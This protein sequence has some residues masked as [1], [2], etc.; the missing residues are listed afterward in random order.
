MPK[1]SVKP[2]SRIKTSVILGGCFLFG[3]IG[4]MDR[5]LYLKLSKWV[6]EK[7][8]EEGVEPYRV[9]SRQAVQGIAESKP[10]TEDEL[11][12]IKGIAEKKLAKYGSEL[13]AIIHEHLGTPADQALFDVD[14]KSDT[15]DEKNDDKIFSVGD[16]L[17]LLNIGLKSSHGKV[18]GEIS[19]LDIRARYLFFGLKDAKDGSLMNVMMWRNDYEL[20]GV[21]LEEGME[22]VVTGNPEIYKPFG[23][24]SFMAKFVE[25]AGEGAL[26]KAYE[27]LKKKL[28]DE[29]VFSDERKKSLPHYPERI[30]VV[31]SKTGAVI[32]D[33]LNNLGKHGYHISFVDCRVEGAYAVRSL[34]AGVRYFKEKNDIDVL[35]VMRGG[36]SLESLQAFNNEKLVRELEECDFPVIA[37]IGHDKDVPLFS[38]AGDVMVS[39]PTAAAKALDQ[40]W[41]EALSTVRLSEQK[42]LSGF[43]QLLSEKKAMLS[44]SMETLREGVSGILEKM[45]RLERVFDTVTGKLGFMI[46]RV[47]Q[48]LERTQKTI[49]ADFENMHRE[50][51]Q[52]LV[53][54]V[55][56]LRAYSPKR[57]LELGYSI[58]SS[59]GKVV[60]ST[61]D[62]KTD[63]KIEIRVVD[64]KI[65]S[66]VEQVKRQEEKK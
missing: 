11:L 16:F 29:G 37:G 10:E 25:H 41:D 4:A 31:T 6:T 42:I 55:K 51:K 28:E 48:N 60:R 13:L 65:H 5:E 3:M 63:D 24:L 57:Q 20:S 21:S 27:E 58:V 34:I 32:H 7:A 66:K 64:G 61:D 44:A 30:G 49:F 36:G 47:R 52:K 26:K 53:R 22:V 38:L 46:E 1:R 9:I 39:T 35:V 56:T 19:S 59:G 50:E 14:S 45:R 40:S 23:R 43:S 62:V 15:E 33:F 18:K 17:E 12:L 54:L 2:H 8:V